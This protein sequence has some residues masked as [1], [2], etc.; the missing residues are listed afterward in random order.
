VGAPFPVTYEHRAQE[1]V[2]RGPGGETE[3]DPTSMGAL[4]MDRGGSEKE[5]TSA[6]LVILI[7]Y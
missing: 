1:S 4:R 3:A 6:R 7:R 5:D 2:V